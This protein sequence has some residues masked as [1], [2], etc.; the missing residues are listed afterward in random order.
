MKL[1]F[2]PGAGASSKE[3]AFQTAYF[4]DSE[5]VI[6]PGH[7]DGEL[8][9]S[10][11]EYTEWLKSYIQRQKYQDVVIVGHSFGGAIALLY[12]LR[13]REDLKA[14]ILVGSGAR[15]RVRPDIL[16]MVRGMIGNA[17]AWKTY[18]ESVPALKN[19]GM[20]AARQD[21][22][23]I[24]PTVLLSDFLCCDSFDIMDK[25][26]DIKVPTLIINGSEDI[27]TPVKYAGY[28]IDKIAGAKLEV[29]DG[30]THDVYIEKPGEVNRAIEKFLET[31]S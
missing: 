17:E 13:H 22:L 9:K 21:M 11:G 1:L 24:G 4:A 31:L 3:W 8:C 15:L 10:V 28:L 2:I 20:E 26:Q 12:A 7:L 18:V 23:K 19:P 6:L 27:M 30:G 5:G 25:V 14:I 29:I 16:D